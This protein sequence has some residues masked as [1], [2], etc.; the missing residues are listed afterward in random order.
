MSS[1]GLGGFCDD[2]RDPNP[3][4]RSWLSEWEGPLGRAHVFQL[5]EGRVVRLE[6]FADPQKAIVS[7]RSARSEARGA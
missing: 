2:R 3:R 1:P 5:R 4:L 6:I 7:V